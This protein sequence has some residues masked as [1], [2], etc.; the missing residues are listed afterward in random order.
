M[1]DLRLSI[2]E[3]MDDLHALPYT[4]IS[5]GFSYSADMQGALVQVCPNHIACHYP[6]TL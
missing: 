2:Y 4:Y 5:V 3:H 6:I 1:D